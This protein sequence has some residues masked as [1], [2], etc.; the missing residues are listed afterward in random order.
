MVRKEKLLSR[1]NYLLTKYQ[2]E[3]YRQLVDYMN[4][5]NLT[6]KDVAKKLGVS[7]SYISQIINGNFNFTLKK[8]IELALMIGK[9]PALEFI[10]FGEFWRKE[11]D[12]NFARPTISVSQDITVY[13]LPVQKVHHIHFTGAMFS[14]NIDTSKNISIKELEYCPN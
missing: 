10:E 1:P 5:N 14:G 2:N 8:L 9:V 3:I 6:Q 12:S 11:K 4:V 7:D 13:I